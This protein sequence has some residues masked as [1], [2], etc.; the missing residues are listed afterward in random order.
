VIT[1]IKKIISKLIIRFIKK[2]TNSSFQKRIKSWAKNPNKEQNAPLTISILITHWLET[3]VPFYNLEYAMH[4]RHLGHKVRLFIDFESFYFNSVSQ[5]TV[6]SIHSVLSLLPDDIEKIYLSD[7]S[8]PAITHPFDNIDNFLWE[9]AIKFF[10]GEE[11][12]S[13]FTPLFETTKKAVYLHYCKI[14]QCIKDNPSDRI[15]IPGGFYGLSGLYVQAAEL[16]GE[17]PVCYDS[18]FEFLLLSINGPAANMTDIPKSYYMLKNSRLLNLDKVSKLALSEIDKRRLGTDLFKYQVTSVTTSNLEEYDILIPLN[19]RVDTAALNIQKVFP[20]VKVWLMSVM[21]WAI[22]NSI[23]VIIRQHPVERFDFARS[24]DDIG[25]LVNKLDPGSKLIRYISADEPVNSYDLLEKCRVVLP[26]ASSI[27]IEAAIL[28]KPVITH[29]EVYYKDL[30]FVFSAQTKEE[31]FTFLQDCLA[32]RKTVT[33]TMYQNALICY[34]LTQNC[35]YIVTRFN[36]QPGNF[37]NWLKIPPR[38]LWQTPACLIVTQAIET[39]TP[40]SFIQAEKILLQ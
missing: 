32:N 38:F 13:R 40:V 26:F 28:K 7:I 27:G 1:E 19:L 21:E 35:N 25:S 23:K 16:I 11:A 4:F 9:N 39:N 12:S 3:P 29:T 36:A 20:S 34:F 22:V 15:L 6:N 5:Q 24:S 33:E 10:N 17:N 30:G 8:A 2:G 31:Y 18:G 37:K 14:F